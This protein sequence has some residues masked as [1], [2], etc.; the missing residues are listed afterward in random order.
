VDAGLAA[1][2]PVNFF[3][4]SP[5]TLSPAG[6]RTADAG[7]RGLSERE[8][9]LSIARMDEAGSAYA[10]GSYD[11]ALNLYRSAAT[12][13]G[14]DTMQALVGTYL[15][16]IR[17]GQDSD[18]QDAFARI[19]ALGLKTRSM[20]VK[21]LFAP[22][23]TE[24]WPD[25]A[26]NKFYPEWLREI[27]RQA[28]DAP[29]C[30]QVVGH[31]SH[32]GA[33]DFNVLLSGQRADAVR[34][35]LETANPALARRIEASGVGWRDNLVGTGSDDLRT[36]STGGS[37]SRWWTAAELSGGAGAPGQRAPSMIQCTS[38]AGVSALRRSWASTCSRKEPLRSCSASAR[39]S[40]GRLLYGA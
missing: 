8:R 37:S 15:S 32:S 6:G 13:P 7:G 17:S 28:G 11:R 26:I 35:Q 39:A 14:V 23:T 19:V 4:E 31:S 22:G 30:L 40:S 10:A 33:E 21:L 9:T 29:S 2:T 38:A 20:G 27:A 12:L 5:F 18:A 36:P 34:Q 25:P 24:F 3:R 16:S 1:A